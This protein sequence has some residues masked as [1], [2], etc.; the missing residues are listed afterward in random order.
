MNSNKVD[1]SP[2]LSIVLVA[3]NMHRELPRTLYTLSSH[4]QTNI[5]QED[6]EVLVVDNGSKPAIGEQIAASIAPNIRYVYNDSDDGSL[7]RAVNLGVSQTR[8]D[9]LGIA[10]DGARMA[11]P[12]V[13][14]LALECF[15]HFKN[16]VVGTVGFHLGHEVQSRSVLR[17][18]DQTE[19]DRLLE[20]IR[21]QDDGYQL[22]EVSTP[23]ASS[24]IPWFSASLE[25]NLF[26]LTREYF[27]NLAGYDERFDL[28]GGGLVNLDF[29]KRAC[30]GP[31]DRVFTLLGEATFHQFH[32]GVMTNR[33]A[34]LT[35]F[36]VRKYLAQY[37]SIRGEKYQPPDTPMYQYGSVRPQ[38]ARALYNSAAQLLTDTQQF[39]SS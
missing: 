34:H 5:A 21:W 25:S 10:V 15:D 16:P 31:C 24:R 11:S 7:S 26:F 6:Y 39:V 28:P 13:L 37:E 23:G 32:G 4:Y 3:Y 12:G 14:G 36:E 2:R 27:E 1:T 38:H 8:S 29:W 9:L 30:A 22:F 35:D 20:S 19:E 17:G 33:P 18:Y